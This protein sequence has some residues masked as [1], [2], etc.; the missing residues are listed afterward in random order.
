MQPF[1]LPEPYLPQP[2]RCSPHVDRAR[3]HTEAWVSRLGLPEPRADYPLLAAY[4]HPDASGDELE[5]LA[6]WYIWAAAAKED[7]DGSS[8][9]RA[10]GD[11]WAHTIPTM[12]SG[13]FE[14]FAEA[15]RR[16]FDTS[17]WEP[18]NHAAPN[19]IDHIAVR[20]AAGPAP[21]SAALVEHATGA[22]LPAEIIDS[23]TIRLL[24][25]S[26]ADSVHLRA[27][28]FRYRQE[29]AAG[30]G[31]RVLERFFGYPP[32][33]AAD[34]V[35]DLITARLRQFESTA[36]ND[37]PPLFDEHGLSAPAR[38]DIRRYVSGLRDWQAGASEWH[39]RSSGH[40]GQ[41]LPRAM[42]LGTSAVRIRSLLG[43][44]GAG[45]PQPARPFARPDLSMPFASRANP[46]VDAVRRHALGWAQ[47]MG[48]LDG[49]V[50]SE[51]RFHAMDFGLFAAL[52]YPDATVAE[53][54]LVNDWHVWS[55][56][57][58]DLFTETFERTL[59]LAAAKAFLA[60][61]RTF[62]Q[63]SPEPANPVE[64]GLADVWSR[65][66]PELP[67]DLRARLA[68]QVRAL[69]D[70]RLWEIVNIVQNRVPDPVDF[71]ETRRAGNAFSTLLV[72]FV[73][74]GDLPDGPP[75]PA[76]SDVFDDVST[77]HSDVISYRGEIG[78]D[79]GINNAVLVV[80]RFL[81]STLDEAVKVVGD[82]RA[83]R[84]RRFEHLTATELPV[85]ADGLDQG[86]RRQLMSYVDGLRDWL[87]GHLRWH[88]VSGRYHSPGP[89][90]RMPAMIGVPRDRA[91]G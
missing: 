51:Q 14:R 17:V 19:P 43:R 55:W 61:P 37:L 77:L 15:S 3:E 32:Q 91:F 73:H 30:N 39:A 36:R 64:R 50:W 82:L 89:Q 62:D 27:D 60:P 40:G 9:R 42:G 20:R 48:M 75:M 24:H 71:L 2:A 54:E 78:S 70:H 44:A 85:V 29:P 46:H 31:V 23:P 28:L 80:Q 22:A 68:G 13:W 8:T 88:Q 35:N 18:D 49:S 11:L 38:R 47:D 1:E 4:T 69:A 90:V 21:W 16:L 84:L 58:E 12:P 81:D 56:Y 59:D 74:G 87:A 34:T 86:A 52:A 72:R 6:A 7:P 83:S 45:L 65:T 67:D 57:L 66:A 76:L 79:A 10:F 53:L 33:R 63:S 26:F 25:N 41:P 5:L